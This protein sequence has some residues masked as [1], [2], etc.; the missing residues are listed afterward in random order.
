[1]SLTDILH[2]SFYTWLAECE[3]SVLRSAIY[4]ESLLRKAKPAGAHFQSHPVGPFPHLHPSNLRV[5]VVHSPRLKT[6]CALLKQLSLLLMWDRET[7]K[8]YYNILLHVLCIP[9][10]LLQ[11]VSERRT[12]L[13]A[14]KRFLIEQKGLAVGGQSG[15]LPSP[16][17]QTTAKTNIPAKIISLYE[18]EGT[19][20]EWVQSLSNVSGTEQGGC[21]AAFWRLQARISAGTS[22]ILIHLSPLFVPQ[23]TPTLIPPSDGCRFLPQP[24]QFI[25]TYHSTISRYIALA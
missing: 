4:Y 3:F 23:E 8:K 20:S 6:S 1:M 21:W 12:I 24:F 19:G 14:V 9:A 13:Q 11:R 18:L 7:E 25:S 15:D 10:S 5:T 2:S 17:T 22:D 16:R